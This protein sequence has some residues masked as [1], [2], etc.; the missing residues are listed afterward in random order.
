MRREK[1]KSRTTLAVLL[2]SL[3]C[4]TIRASSPGAPADFERTYPS[5]TTSHLS[6]YNLNGEI[7]VSAWD[8]RAIAVRASTTRASL[9][10]DSVAGEDISIRVKRQFRPVRVDFDIFVPPDTSVSL[11]NVIGNIEVKG[12]RGHLRISSIGSDV[13]LIGVNSNSFDVRVTSGDIY[14]DGDLHQ[15]GSYGLQTMKGDID[16]TLPVHTPFNLNA[17]ALTSDINLGAFLSELTGGNKTSRGI[18]GT[19]LSGGPRLDLT[20]YAG[21]IF[22]HKK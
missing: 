8:K 13:R 5:R 18:S 10:Q 17:R 12:V 20:T 3:F 15:D 4:L 14:F 7:R 16:V 22:L 6:V 2:L 1:R 9:I 21:K 11:D 19:H